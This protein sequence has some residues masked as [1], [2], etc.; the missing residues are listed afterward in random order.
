MGKPYTPLNEG[1][2]DLLGN[3]LQSDLPFRLVEL[4]RRW[5]EVAG[6]EVAS[7]ARPLGRRK[8]TLVL[9]A[10][11]SQTLQEVTYYITEILDRVNSYLGE[12]VFEKVKIE[13]VSDKNPLDMTPGAHV[14]SYVPPAVP[15]QLGSLKDTLESESPVTACYHKYVSYMAELKKPM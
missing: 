13:H 4:Y 7:M 9:A 10:E 1:L 2:Q 5:P 12:S 14:E 11:D 3:T 6:E 15:D 8:S